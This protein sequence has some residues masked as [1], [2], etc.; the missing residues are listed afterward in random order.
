MEQF[1]IYLRQLKF[2]IVYVMTAIF[3][4]IR[5]NMEIEPTDKRTNEKFEWTKKMGKRER[6]GS[7]SGRGW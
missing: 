4:C 5:Y 1:A 3:H 6:W 2:V 7:R